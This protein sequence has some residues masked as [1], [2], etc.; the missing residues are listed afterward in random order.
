MSNVVPFRLRNG[1][2]RPPAS[3]GTPP[4]RVPKRQRRSREHLTAD[5]VARLIQAAGTVG[6][7]GARDAALILLAYRHGLRVSELVA[8]RWDQVDLEH[9]TRHVNRSKFGPPTIWH[10]CWGRA[11]R[12]Q[13]QPLE[14]SACHRSIG[15]G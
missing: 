7:H 14:L 15:D 6:R 4:G 12:V 11:A 1:A 3:S 5:E 2:V 9:G 8:L 13:R 10:L